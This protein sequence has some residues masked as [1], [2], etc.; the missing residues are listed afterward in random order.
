MQVHPK[1]G[2]V[3]IKKKSTSSQD[4]PFILASQ[5]QQVFYLDF[6][7]D[8]KKLLEWVVAT[9]AFARSRIDWTNI[10]EDDDNNVDFFQEEEQLVPLP[11]EPTRELDND[12]ILLVPDLYNDD[13]VPTRFANDAEYEVSEDNEED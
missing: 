10:Q 1:N 8:D 11:I 12:T 5:A 9:K 13:V 7:S 2:I 4:D 6:M 3:Q